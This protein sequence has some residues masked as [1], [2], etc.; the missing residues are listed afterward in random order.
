MKVIKWL[1]AIGFCTALYFTAVITSAIVNKESIPDA[2]TTVHEF[3]EDKIE[4]AQDWAFD[5]MNSGKERIE[6]SSVMQSVDADKAITDM[7]KKVADSIE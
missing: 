5:T 4:D 1:I 6:N 7:T 2:V 3:I